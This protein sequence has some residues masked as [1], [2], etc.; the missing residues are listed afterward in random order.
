MTNIIFQSVFFLSAMATSVGYVHM[1]QLESYQTPG[2]LRWLKANPDAASVRLMPAVLALVASLWYFE[3]ISLVCA[4]LLLI[5]SWIGGFKKAKKPLKI[6]A[7]AVRLFVILGILLGGASF[8]IWLP[9]GRYALCLA[10]VAYI[11]LPFLVMLANIISLPLQKAVNGRYIRDAKRRLAGHPGLTVIGVTGSYGKTSVK[12]VIKSLLE[13]KYGVLATPESFNTPMG[14]VRSIREGLSAA[15]QIFVCEMGARHRGDIRE[16]CDIVSPDHGVITAVGSMH[17]ETFGTVDA[18]ADTKFE[19]ADALKPG[20]K[21]FLCSDY[22]HIRERAGQNAVTYGLDTQY[23]PD[24]WADGISADAD[25]T[26]FTVHTRDGREQSFSTQLLGRHQVLNILA[27]IAVADAFDIPLNKLPAAVRAIRPVAH[28]LQL[29]KGGKINI[30][31]DAFNANPAGAKA[32]L[33]VLSMFDGLKALV[34]PGMIELG[35]SQEEL[36][37]AF[38]AQAA[39]ICDYVALVG[40]KQTLSVA[41]GLRD[42]GFPPERQGVFGTLEEAL[43]WVKSV[44]DGRDFYILLENDLPDNY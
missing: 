10:L 28:R 11:A 41:Q 21:A 29:I 30:I 15:H 12:Q 38:G 13:V 40:E 17:L 43:T 18:V 26:R 6:T 1:L 34:T 27:G 20:G 9:F 42:A 3:Y 23:N 31:D 25:G 16:I 4:G 37:R 35:D 39:E 19:L 33:Q 5:P 24:F 22:P 8:L 7:R 14:V 44:K 36:N 32:A 2:F